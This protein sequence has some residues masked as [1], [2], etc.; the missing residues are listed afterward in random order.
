MILAV[1]EGTFERPSFALPPTILEYT[2]R[3]GL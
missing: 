1:F 2:K 3:H